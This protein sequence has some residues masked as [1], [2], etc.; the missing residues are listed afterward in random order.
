MESYS[1][2]AERFN[3]SASKSAS[4]A[5]KIIGELKIKKGQHIIDFGSGGGYFVNIF[6]ENIG[7]EG[8]VYAVDVDEDLL[9]Y[10]LRNTDKQN[11][12]TVLY[13]GDDFNITLDSIDLVFMRN[14]THHLK[15]RVDIF[16]KLGELLKPSGKI[17][18]VDYKRNISRL[19]SGM[20]GHS[21][22]KSKI[23]KEMSDAG[24]SFDKSFEFIKNQHFMIFQ[25]K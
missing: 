4:R 11:I 2:R 22:R 12:K 6:S 10:I 23:I 3:A 8:V 14:V 7:E 15:N 18:I 24:F 16:K 13:A 25:L 20:Y 5:E 9:N 19:F 21:V 1:E 17:A